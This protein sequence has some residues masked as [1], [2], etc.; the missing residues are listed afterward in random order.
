[1][2]SVCW[3]QD[4]APLTTS[5]PPKQET[6]RFGNPTST[7]RAYQHLKL[8]V[9][10]EIK[11]DELVLDKT[12]Y[13]D[14]QSFKVTPSTKFYHDSKKADLSM[15]KVGDQVFVQVKTNKK[16]G[17]LVVEVVAWGVVGGRMKGA[18]IKR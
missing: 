5:D 6:A 18:G 16:T 13:G 17:D 10:K 15:L 7:A 4:S 14:G 9:I 11:S 1:M 12:P 8:G 3:G 2:A